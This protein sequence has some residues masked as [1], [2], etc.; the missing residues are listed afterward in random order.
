[1]NVHQVPPRDTQWGWGGHQ[2]PQAAEERGAQHLA[3]S[4]PVGGLGSDAPTCLLQLKSLTLLL[5][6]QDPHPP[7]PLLFLQFFP[8]ALYWV[9]LSPP[10]WIFS[11]NTAASVVSTSPPVT[12]KPFSV[13]LTPS[14]SSR[15]CHFHLSAG[16][17]HMDGLLTQ[18]PD[19][20][21]RS[22]I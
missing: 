19:W 5:P 21:R 16:C 2:C 3:W 17:L 18:P 4:Q 12:P 6:L 14:L 1:M 20:M 11:S 7:L 9:F 15:S 8:K 13:A 10:P 22:P